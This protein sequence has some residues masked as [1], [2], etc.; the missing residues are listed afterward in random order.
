[1][2][3]RSRID[4]RQAN[5][6]RQYSA[7]LAVL[8]IRAHSEQTVRLGLVALAIEDLTAADARGLLVPVSFLFH[9]AQRIGSDPSRL[10]REV[11]E[12]SGPGVAAM[13]LD[14]LNRFPE[15]QTIESVGWQEVETPYGLGFMLGQS[16]PGV[17]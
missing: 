6:L 10:F 2:Y 4:W 9:A 7:V 3:T 15:M 13:L 12:I 8:G 17:G 11:A 14:F 16:K 5:K 1:M